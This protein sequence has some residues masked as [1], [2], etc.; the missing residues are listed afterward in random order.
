M[1]LRLYELSTHHW[2]DGHMHVWHLCAGSKGYQSWA[3]DTLAS[4]TWL[5]LVGQ[6]ASVLVQAAGGEGGSAPKRDDLSLI[7]VRSADSL[8]R[9]ANVWDAT[10]GLWLQVPLGVR[11]L[12]PLLTDYAIQTITEKEVDE[13]APYASAVTVWTAR[14]GLPAPDGRTGIKVPLYDRQADFDDPVQ[15]D[16]YQGTGG[17][18]GPAE[19]KDVLK[20]VPLGH[21]PKAVPTYLGIIDDLHRWSIGGGRAIQGVPRAWAFGVR[22]TQTAGAPTSNQ[23]AVD[24]ATG[25]ITTAVKPEGFRVE[26]QGRT[27]GGIWKRYIGELTAALALEAGLVTS[28]DIAGMDATPRT[29]G[30]YLSAGDGR[31]HKDVY[32][33]LVGSVAR[34]RWYIDLSDQLVVARLPRGAGAASSRSYSTADGSTPGAK[35]LTRSNTPPAKQVVLRYAEN[36]NP[37]TQTAYDATDPGD[38]AFWTSQWR[39]VAGETDAAIV[40]AYGKGAKVATVETSLSLAS[41]AAA[42]LPAWVAE[43]MSPPLPY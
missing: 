40:A 20:E 3:S 39:E 11:P 19:M 18:E 12:N 7:N 23:Y 16:R 10:A 34:G 21:V 36:P 42:E 15:V 29:V 37:V 9:Y 24:L 5:P 41:D 30:V 13:A 28:V 6:W 27:F 1:K 38:I 31:S 32:D 26:V 17:Y 2:A 14:A 8:P 25:I 35:P 43:K 22:M 4:V 33:K